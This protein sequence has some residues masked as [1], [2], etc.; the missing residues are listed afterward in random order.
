MARMTI[1]PHMQAIDR[2]LDEDAQLMQ[3]AR[4]DPRA[5]APLYEKYQ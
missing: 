4:T 5:F 3:R 2:F 1:D